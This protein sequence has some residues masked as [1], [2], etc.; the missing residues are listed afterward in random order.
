MKSFKNALALGVLALGALGTSALA[1]DTYVT[2]PNTV[3]CQACGAEYH[4]KAKVM[5]GNAIQLKLEQI[6][7]TANPKTR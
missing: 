5:K 3:R 4:V 1:E 7:K 6:N 2:F